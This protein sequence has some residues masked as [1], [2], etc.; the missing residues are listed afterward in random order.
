MQCI[1]QR[2]CWGTPP[3]IKN[4]SSSAADFSSMPNNAGFGIFDIG[5]L[6][7]FIHGA[8][9]HVLNC[10]C[11]LNLTLV[12]KQHGAAIAMSW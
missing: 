9:V 8:T 1:A 4:D 2:R 11:P 6:S 5:T 3:I 12:Y 10:L 7:D